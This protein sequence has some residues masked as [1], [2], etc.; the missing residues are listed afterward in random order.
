MDMTTA[1]TLVPGV[2]KIRIT[3]TARTGPMIG[4][5]EDPIPQ[6]SDVGLVCTFKRLDYGGE[7]SWDVLVLVRDDGQH[8]FAV[9]E[10]CEETSK[11]GS[12]AAP[13]AEGGNAEIAAKHA[14][15]FQTLKGMVKPFP[16]NGHGFSNGVFLKCLHQAV[17]EQLGIPV[18]KSIPIG[19]DGE[20]VRCGPYTWS[21]EQLAEEIAGG[22]WEIDITKRMKL[23]ELNDLISFLTLCGG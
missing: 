22:F 1:R 12:V 19:W 7:G 8:L 9:N 2:S 16:E 4:S 5:V 10:D 11:E 20:Y 23:D 15:L 6:E 21:V 3:S 13:A 18:G 14:A 17:E